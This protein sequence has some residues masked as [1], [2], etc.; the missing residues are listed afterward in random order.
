[1]ILVLVEKA[2]GFIKSRKSEP[3]V[4]DMSAQM[5]EFAGLNGIDLLDVKVDR[6]GSYDYD[7]P[8]INE[9]MEGL[10]TGTYSLIL[11]RDINDITRDREQ[12]EE[13]LR[14]V[15]DYGGTVVSIYDGPIRIG[16]DE[17]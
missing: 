6:Q 1:M 16:D 3:V 15:R 2:Y 11:I 8:K 12:Q 4:I 14:Q 9:L 13:F 7:R 5:H 17:C 10:E